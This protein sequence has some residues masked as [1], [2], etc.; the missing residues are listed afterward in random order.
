MPFNLQSQYSPFTQQIK[1]MSTAKYSVSLENLFKVH[2]KMRALESIV[3][4]MESHIESCWQCWEEFYLY[5]CIT[6]R[7]KEAQA[8]LDRFDNKYDPLNKSRNDIEYA[9]CKFTTLTRSL[10]RCLNSWGLDAMKDKDYIEDYQKFLKA[11]EKFHELAA[12]LQNDAVD[13]HIDP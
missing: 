5:D 8:L 1:I 2:Q 9:I 3:S 4:E 12:S 7:F 10:D 11:F 13:L 6:E